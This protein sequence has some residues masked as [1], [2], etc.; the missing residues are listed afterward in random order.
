MLAWTRPLSLH[1]SMRSIAV[2]IQQRVIANISNRTYEL[3]D[4]IEHPARC[5][6]HSG[7][8]SA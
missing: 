7:R 4:S 8:F 5:L 3:H 1:P 6:A 2:A